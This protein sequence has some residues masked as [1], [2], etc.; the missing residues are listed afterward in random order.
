MALQ[1]LTLACCN[2]LQHQAPSDTSSACMQD[3]EGL[4]VL[5]SLHLCSFH[6][7]DPL[8]FL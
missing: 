8:T 1:A 6:T 3:S 2:M 7:L 4:I 5:R